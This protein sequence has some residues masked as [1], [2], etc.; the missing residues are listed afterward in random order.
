MAF[1]AFSI[2]GRALACAVLITAATVETA[3][4]AAINLLPQRS[5]TVGYI[6]TTFNGA[7]SPFFGPGP[8]SDLVSQFVGSPGNQVQADASM[9]SDANG[10]SFTGTG[11]ATVGFSAEELDG[12]FSSVVY[13]VLFE[14]TSSHSY[15]ISGLL[16]A[17][18]DGGVGIAQFDL[19][20]FLGASI[21]NETA[22]SF[23][24][25]AL[26]D[27]GT[28][29]AGFCALTV[30]ADVNNGGFFQPGAFHAGSAEF[31]F[32]FTLTE[33]STPVPA[34]ASFGLLALGLISAPLLRRRRR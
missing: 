19:S 25:Q 31:D 26:A 16:D 8:Y 14:L 24:T 27:S 20:V 12:V 21:Y 4:A 15:S 6:G 3:S 10:S 29:G 17:N 28:L 22:S 1:K 13:S 18:V 34:P 2:A 7:G 5:V 33:D 32:T 23:A 11:V 30:T 9:A